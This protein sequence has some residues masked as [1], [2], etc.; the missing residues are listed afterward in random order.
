VFALAVRLRLGGEGAPARSFAW[1][2]SVRYAVLMGLLVQAATACSGIAYGAWLTGRLSSWLPAPPAEWVGVTVDGWGLV[3][4]LAAGLWLPGFLALVLGFR[5]LAQGFVLVAV[6]VDALSKTWLIAGSPALPN[7]YLLSEI[8]LAVGLLAAFRADTPQLAG[9]RWLTVLPIALLVSAV[10]LL[11]PLVS[12]DAVVSG[13]D[14]LVCGSLIAV[15]AV[16]VVRL[17]F[18]PDLHSPAWSMALAMLAVPIVGLRLMTLAQYAGLG[19]LSDY[20]SRV[21]AWIT[22]GIVEVVVLAAFAVGLAIHARTRL[23]ELSYERTP[24]SVA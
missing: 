8:L 15:M 6:A 10:P 16:T 1:G 11:L 7:L 19:H 22:A 17:R 21:P 12:A 13:V 9:N 18:G 14:E 20:G 4:F 3:T 24:A 2:Q 23:A 5:R